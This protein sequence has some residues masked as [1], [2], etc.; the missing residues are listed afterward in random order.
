M[1]NGVSDDQASRSSN[2]A[3]R[4][5]SHLILGEF[6]GQAYRQPQNHEHSRACEH[7][8]QPKFDP[9][10]DPISM[11]RQKCVLTPDTPKALDLR[12]WIQGLGSKGLGSLGFM[13][14]DLRPW[15]HGLGCMTLD[16]RPWI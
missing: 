11:S 1:A 10:F 2:T 13:A 8:I 16:P 3:R 12:P 7:C 4:Q 9:D 6:A 5:R 14:L 15:I